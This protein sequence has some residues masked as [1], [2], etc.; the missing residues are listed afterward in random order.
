MSEDLISAS[1]LCGLI[2]R[3][4]EQDDAT[5]WGD[6]EKGLFRLINEGQHS[7]LTPGTRFTVDGRDMVVVPVEALETMRDDIADGDEGEAFRCLTAMIA[8]AIAAA[9]E[10]D[11]P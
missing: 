4:L 10:P 1:G 8:K 5:H 2:R 7:T 11:A 9:S 3:W 6:F